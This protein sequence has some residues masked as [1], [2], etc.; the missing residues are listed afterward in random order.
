MKR[1]AIIGGGAAG[2]FCAANIG[3]GI[4]ATLFEASATLMRKVLLSGGGRCNFSNEN[5]DTRRSD[6]RAHV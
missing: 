5:I 2:M 1:V 4:E 6:G 3:E